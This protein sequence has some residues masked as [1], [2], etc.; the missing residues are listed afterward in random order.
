MELRDGWW[1]SPWLPTLDSNSPGPKGYYLCWRAGNGSGAQQGNFGQ[2]MI[3]MAYVAPQNTPLA[4]AAIRP[5]GSPTGCGPLYANAL[6]KTNQSV[7]VE[8]GLE[9]PLRQSSA[10][11]PPIYLR[12]AHSQSL[13]QMVDC[14]ASPRG[15]DEE[16]RDGCFTP[17]QLNTRDLACAPLW[18][19]PTLPPNLPPPDPSPI[20]D[21][22]EAN[23]GQVTSMSKGLE[24]PVRGSATL[25]RWLSSQS[26]GLRI[27]WP[28][29]FQRK[30]TRGSWCSS[31][32][33]TARSTRTDFAPFPSPSSHPSTS[34][35]GSRRTVQQMAQGCPRQ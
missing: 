23:P 28:A 8:V 13:N 33:S 18:T 16:I 12:V 26:V 27:E 22:I 20:P 5:P 25:R 14:D 9:P 2:Q 29:S 21:C 1:E 3:Q 11:D 4:Y 32:R 19:N 31:L 10:T 7:C 17:Y 15:P 30:M 35:A 34:P 24:G 6:P